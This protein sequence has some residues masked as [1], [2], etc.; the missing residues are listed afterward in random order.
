[1]LDEARD[2]AATARGAPGLQGRRVLVEIDGLRPMPAKRPRV[3][4]GG[5]HNEPG[6]AAYLDRLR[7]EILAQAGRPMLE[8]PLSLSVAFWG[9]RKNADLSNLVKAIEDAGQGLLYGNDNQIQSL[10][11]IRCVDKRLR[12]RF[13]VAMI[14]DAA[15]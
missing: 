12:I 3:D 6:Y 14:Q 5:A 13:S 7:G 1:M 4:R 2:G 9:A 11:A 8:G 15:G 10:E